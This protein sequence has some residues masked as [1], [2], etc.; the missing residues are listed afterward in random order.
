MYTQSG[1]MDRGYIC[2]G[3]RKIACLQNMSKRPYINFLYTM[4]CIAKRVKV[5]ELLNFHDHVHAGLS[6]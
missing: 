6:S 5:C 3:K 1:A 4:Q 2:A